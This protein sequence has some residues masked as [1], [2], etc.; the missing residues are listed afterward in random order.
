MKHY[1]YLIM[2]GG[3]AGGAAVRGIRKIDTIG[4][5]GMISMDPDP[6]YLRPIFQRDY[7]KVFHESILLRVLMGVRSHVPEH[8]KLTACT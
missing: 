5:V 8:D 4:S 2:G 7:G 3:L 1:P 6:P